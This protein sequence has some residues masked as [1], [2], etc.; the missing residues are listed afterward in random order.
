MRDVTLSKRAA[1][2]GFRDRVRKLL[3]PGPIPRIG[4]G[5]KMEKGEIL[6]SDRHSVLGKTDSSDGDVGG[7]RRRPAVLTRV[8]WSALF[9]LF[10]SLITLFS[11][12]SKR[13][14]PPSGMP[15]ARCDSS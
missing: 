4:L 3:V 14:E 5:D 7:G 11:P 1:F 15:R 12:F 6:G 2:S 9:A 8:P 13:A 10:L